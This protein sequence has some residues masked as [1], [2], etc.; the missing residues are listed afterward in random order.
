MIL[1]NI[2][3]TKKNL[4]SRS[5]DKKIWIIKG[6]FFL[7]FFLILT[8]SLELQIFQTNEL[9]QM[10]IN[11][12][13]RF[14]KLQTQRGSIYDSKGEILSSS[15]PYYSAFILTKQLKN[16]RDTIEKL[17]HILPQTSEEISKKIYSK[18][19]FIWLDKLFHYEQKKK[20]RI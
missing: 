10:A 1:D 18:K 6:F 17:T 2:R 5:F 11:Q 12:Y 16:R 19:K 15:V 3:H 4:S 14:K 7:I 8:R 20:L 9:D 13:Q